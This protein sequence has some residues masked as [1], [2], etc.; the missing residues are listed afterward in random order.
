MRAQHWA[1]AGRRALLHAWCRSRRRHVA[2]KVCSGHRN[3]ATV[4]GRQRFV[5]SWRP[6]ARYRA[7]A[8][9]GAL[10]AFRRWR[11]EP[12]D[13]VAVSFKALRGLQGG[14][15][16]S[17]ADAPPSHMQLHPPPIHL[18]CA[19][20]LVGRNGFAFGRSG[21][22]FGC[23]GFA[24]GRSGTATL[25]AICRAASLFLQELLDL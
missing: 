7:N 10:G 16:P 21:F 22:A 8:R 17:S 9:A 24:L 20:F 14:N 3:K 15:P 1:A 2:T 25:T 5:S 13:L 12:T 11:R 6:R 19:C 18:C 23:S 4:S